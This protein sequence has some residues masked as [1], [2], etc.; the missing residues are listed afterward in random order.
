MFTKNT[1][2]DLCILM[3][4]FIFLFACDIVL[5]ETLSDIQHVF[6]NQ[7]NSVRLTK[8]FF[9]QALTAAC[10]ISRKIR[11]CNLPPFDCQLDFFDKVVLLLFCSMNTVG[12]F[13]Y[14]SEGITCKK[15]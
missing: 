4:L 3:N 7:D 13:L 8:Y 2:V 12:G 10:N 14:S 9:V 11:L 1:E 6:Q 5:S 15:D